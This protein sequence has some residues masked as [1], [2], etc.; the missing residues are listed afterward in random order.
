[1]TSRAS[2]V[3]V[4]NSHID[5]VWLWPWEEGLAATLSTFRAAADLCDTHDGFVFCHN[6]ALLYRWVEEHEPAI[7]TLGAAGFF[8]IAVV[9]A[10]A[11]AP[12]FVYLGYV[13]G[14]ELERLIA[15]VG[16]SEAAALTRVDHLLLRR[17]AEE[18]SD[19]A[20][21]ELVRRHLDHTYSVAL[22]E[23][24]DPHLAADVSNAIASSYL[25]HT[26]NIRIRSSQSFQARAETCS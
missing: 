21:A 3:L 19:E 6:E 11:S 22:R 2:L 13:F 14:D 16:G 18:G 7:E 25:E 5:P 1:M 26:Y 15:R 24:N 17:Y 12:G 23:V 10:L 9:A 20:F 4:C 8:G